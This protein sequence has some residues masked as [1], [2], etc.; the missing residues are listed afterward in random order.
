MTRAAISARATNS[1]GKATSIEEE[2]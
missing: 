2:A 1:E